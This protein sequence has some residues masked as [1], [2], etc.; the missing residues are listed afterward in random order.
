MKINLTEKNNNNNNGRLGMWKTYAFN[1]G[2]I[3]PNC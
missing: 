2:N 3:I 1:I